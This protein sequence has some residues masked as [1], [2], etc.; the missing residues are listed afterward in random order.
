VSQPMSWE[1]ATQKFKRL[2]AP[3]ATDAEGKAITNAVAD[4]DNTRVRDLMR[5][6]SSVR[7]HNQAGSRKHA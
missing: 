1:L 3:Y 5:L 4:M 7:I 2:A 6:L